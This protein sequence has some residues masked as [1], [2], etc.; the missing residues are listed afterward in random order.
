MNR[1]RKIYRLAYGIALFIIAV[2]MLS[3][4]AKILYP[5]DFAVSVY[6]FQLLPGALVNLAALYIPWLEMVCGVCLLI[7]P[8]LRV[9]A[10]WI[11]LLL[12]IGFTVAIGINLW[13]GSV[14][15]CGC[16]GSGA[17]DEPLNGLHLLRN[18][19]LICLTGLALYIRKRA[20][21]SGDPAD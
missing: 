11:V 1:D 21:A 18:A 6:R 17:A 3:G 16:F 9:A 7:V 4:Y 12:L 5:D 20:T 14:F 2:V 10:L 19:G 8:R 13:R 15:G